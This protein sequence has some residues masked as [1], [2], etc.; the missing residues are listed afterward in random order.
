MA[1]ASRILSSYRRWLGRDL[2]A[3][4]PDASPETRARALFDAPIVVL[5]HGT[6]ADPVLNYGNRT[7]LTL[8][9][10]DWAA[11]TRMPS[12]LTAEPALREDRAKLLADVLRQGYSEGYR[13]V[14]I[15]RTGNR[16]RIEQATVWNLIDEQAAPCGQAATFSSWVPL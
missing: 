9:E 4:P 2:L 16:F 10:M 12:R 15:S 6:Q 8:W 13:G 1:Q 11:L 14:R 7:A 5:S 3:L